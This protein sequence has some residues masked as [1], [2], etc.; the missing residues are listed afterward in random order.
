MSRAPELVEQQQEDVEDVEE[1]ARRDRYG[2]A[3]SSCQ[4]RLKSTIVNPP[5]I[6]SP[7]TA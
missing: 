7:A 4:S 3:T 6:A 1:D 5:K 2:A